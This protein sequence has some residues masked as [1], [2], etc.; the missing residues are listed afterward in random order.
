MWT[1]LSDEM[2]TAIYINL[3]SDPAK[4]SISMKSLT[5]MFQLKVLFF[6]R[7]IYGC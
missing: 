5:G 6:K 7:V 2:E 4:N 3:S 1:K